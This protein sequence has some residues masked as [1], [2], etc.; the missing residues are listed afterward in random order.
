MEGPSNT[1]MRAGVGGGERS[2]NIIKSK[3]YVT[4]RSSE[5]FALSRYPWTVPGR[6]K[7]IS[8]CHW[9]M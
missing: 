8:L 2:S 4:E 9:D 5:K 1:E 7:R 3:Y 6:R